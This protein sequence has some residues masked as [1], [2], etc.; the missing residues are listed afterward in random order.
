MTSLPLLSVHVP[1][2]WPLEVANSLLV[3][4][5][6]KWLDEASTVEFIA[7]L[8]SFPIQ[9]DQE[10]S[11]RALRETLSVAREEGLSAYDAAYLE[12]AMRHGLPLATLD[13]RLRVAAAAVGVS[14]YA[15]P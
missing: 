4:E 7:L 9:V 14:L 13:Q 10:T 15:V 6:R 5:R 3:G 11:D 1:A 12:L 2:H 8:A